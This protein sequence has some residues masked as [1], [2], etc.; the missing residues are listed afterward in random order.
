MLLIRHRLQLTLVENLKVKILKTLKKYCK[1][2]EISARLWQIF[3]CEKI[4]M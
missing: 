2:F 3:A 4:R 1:M